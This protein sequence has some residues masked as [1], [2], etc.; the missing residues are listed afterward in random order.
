[1]EII[2]NIKK[3]FNF[4][5]LNFNQNYIPS[6]LQQLS[7]SSILKKK[8]SL[9]RVKLF[10]ENQDGYRKGRSCF[11]TNFFQIFSQARTL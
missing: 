2:I 10:P 3:E 7:S 11:S 8:S 6:F 9:N 4:L 5:N 1:M